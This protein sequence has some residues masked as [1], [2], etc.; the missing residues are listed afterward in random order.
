MTLT[1]SL[2][3]QLELL[4]QAKLWSPA[5]LKRNRG[6]VLR[7]SKM[8]GRNATP[9][10]LTEDQIDRYAEDMTARGMADW[11][12]DRDRLTLQMLARFMAGE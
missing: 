2:M 8:L 1:I 11:T 5:S 3:G 9:E 6:A 10:D 7:F 4:A 12:V